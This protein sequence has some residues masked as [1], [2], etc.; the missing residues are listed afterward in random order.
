MKFSPGFAAALILALTLTACGEQ[1]IPP[2]AATE[3]PPAVTQVTEAAIPDPMEVTTAPTEAPSAPTEPEHSPLYIPGLSVEDVIL[4]FNEVCLNAEFINSGDPTRLQKW[5]SPIRYAI[6][7][8]PTET[9]LDTIGG[10]ALW[11]NRM[12]CFPGIWEADSEETANLRI[13]FCTAAEMVDRMGD[14][15]TGLDGC[16]TFWYEED[17]IYDAIICC[18]TEIPQYLRNSVILEEIYNGLGPIQDTDL[19]PDSIIYSEYSEPQEL[20]DIDRLILKLLYHPD[21]KC[22]MDARQCEAVIRALYY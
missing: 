3:G 12:E 9:D 6:H 5:E 11:L 4:C 10:F 1:N 18:R 14:N 2:Q 8:E 22:G 15:F 20:T 13:Y 21:M 16:V 17:R 7:G 19:R